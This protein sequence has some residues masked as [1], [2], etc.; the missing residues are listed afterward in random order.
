M[1]LISDKDKRNFQNLEKTFNSGGVTNAFVMALKKR[2]T[3]DTGYLHSQMIL[4]AVNE[5]LRL[6][7]SKNQMSEN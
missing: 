1:K 5:C 4:D 6:R 2:D 7:K 3:M